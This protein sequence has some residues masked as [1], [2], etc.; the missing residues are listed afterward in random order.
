M[1]VNY[2]ID[3]TSSAILLVVQHKGKKFRISTGN[4]IRPV[5]QWDSADQKVKSS[6]NKLYV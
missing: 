6:F 3:T 5:S 1:T 2:Y 4:I